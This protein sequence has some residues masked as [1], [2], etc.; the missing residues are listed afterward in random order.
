M[1]DRQLSG[2]SG[3]E[4]RDR[5]AELGIIAQERAG[6]TDRAVAYLRAAV[7]GDQP[8]ARALAELRGIARGRGDWEQVIQLSEQEVEVSSD[9]ATRVRLLEEAA[10]IK[11][12]QLLDR[13][14]AAALF[15]RA[16]SL[17]DHCQPALSFFA[18]YYFDTEQ[19]EDAL[20]V[21]ENFEAA[22]AAI[23]LDEDD[24][25][26]IDATGFYYKYGVVLAHGGREEETLGRFARALELTPTHLPS[27]EAAAP[28]YFDAQDWEKARQSSRAIL[29]LRGGTGDSASLTELYLRLGR[30]ELELGDSTSALK[31]FKKALDRTPNHVAALQGIASIHRLS[32]DWNSLLSTYNSIIKYARDPDQVIQ[33]YMTKGDVL[34]QKLQFT[35]KAVLHYEKVLMYDKTNWDATAR[36]GQIALRRGELDRAGDLAS[37]ASKAAG[38]EHEKTQSV[39]LSKLCA[40]PDIFD[41]GTLLADVRADVGEGD[42]GVL[43]VFQGALEGD[44]E[45][46]RDRAAEAF[47][48]T[49]RAL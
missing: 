46:A 8:S 2:L 14:G 7:S 20:P 28:R 30:C 48:D 31:R 38:N 17:D 18:D 26:R 15:K 19:W 25:A 16:L 22:I 29:R 36:L 12:D 40:G 42:D 3:L 5:H 6:E 24:D 9:A 32:E 37:K 49:F 35:D 43:T 39:L 44:T 34:E 1:A 11:L 13:D 23:D 4:L 21:F 27:L 33:A 41:V 45:V 10:R 47:R